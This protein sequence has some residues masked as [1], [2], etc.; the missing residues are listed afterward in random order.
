MPAVLEKG[1][2][3]LEAHLCHIFRMYLARGYVPRAW[4][5]IKVMLFLNPGSLTI[6]RLRHIVL[7]LYL[8]SS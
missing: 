7:L 6:P 1:T 3:H 5:Q 4:R 8:P 2:E